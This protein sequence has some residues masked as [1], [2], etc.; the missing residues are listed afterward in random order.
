MSETHITRRARGRTPVKQELERLDRISDEDIADAVAS[1]PD[2][3]PL[4]PASWFES[5]D[6]VFPPGK[7][8]ISI[9]LDKDVL[10]Y[11]HSTGRRYQTRI[12]A[13]LKAYVR[14][15]SRRAAR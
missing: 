14:A 6:V 8:L 9:R 5:A 4:L 1:D 12:N 3:A 11:F 7:K 2:A 13:V 10:D 15:Q